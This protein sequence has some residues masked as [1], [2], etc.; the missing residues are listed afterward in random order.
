MSVFPRLLLFI[1]FPGVFQRWEFK[2]TTKNVLKKSCRTFFTKISTKNPKLCQNR[3]LHDF[4]LTFLGVGRFSMR[5]V[6]KHDK[7]DIEKKNL[8]SFLFR[9]LALTHP[10]TTGSPIFFGAAPCAASPLFAVWRPLP[11]PLAPLPLEQPPH[12]LVHMRQ[13]GRRWC[14]HIFSGSGAS[15]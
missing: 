14:G 8:T 6:Q 7:A 3:L 10:P 2:N 15:N 12:Q 5:G 1:A 4:F 13:W 11:L 9:T